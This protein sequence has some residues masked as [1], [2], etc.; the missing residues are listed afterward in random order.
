MRRL[1]VLLASLTLCAVGIPAVGASTPTATPAASPSPSPTPCAPGDSVCQQLQAALQ[2]Q[3]QLEA[4]KLA[5]AGEIRAARDEQTNLASLVLATKKSIDET[6]GEITVEQQKLADATAG[7]KAARQVAAEARESARRDRDRLALV[8]RAQYERS[9]TFLAY[10]IDADSLADLINRIAEV[11]QLTDGSSVL[12]ERLREEERLADRKEAEALEDE[13][14]AQ[15]AA[16]DLTTRKA[17]LEAQVQHEQDLITR[18]DVQAGAAAREIAQADSQD[19]AVVQRIAELRIQQLDATIAE[20]EKAAWDE[21][22]YYLANHLSGLPTS[23]TVTAWSAAQAA[24]AG[25]LI[26]PA[27]GTTLSQPFGPSP[28]PFEPPAFGAPHF[29]T[30]IDL[31][32]PLGTPVYAAAGGEVL[33]A[34]RGDTGYGNHVVIAHDQHTLSLYGHLSV[35]LVTPGQVVVAGQPIGLMGST[36]NSTGPHLHFEMRIDSVPVDPMPFLPPLPVGASGPPP[37]VS[38]PPLPPQP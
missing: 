19:A 29:H 7:A 8:L 10:L 31:A 4:T 13:A 24:G 20:A 15:Q 30:G 23:V 16:Q 36:G 14:V 28:Y 1:I 34:T 25:H 17:D 9:D 22:Q 11:R 27:P 3:A 33:A 35:M 5:L 12:L 18:L 26:W 37:L 21:A 32:G 2:R 6:V 38:P